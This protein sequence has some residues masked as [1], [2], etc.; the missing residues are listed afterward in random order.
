MARCKTCEK[1]RPKYTARTRQLTRF[2]ITPDDF[3][4]LFEQQGGV[5]ALCCRAESRSD[6]RWSETIWTLAVDHDHGHC[7]N[8]RACKECIRGLL[9]ASC[10]T[11]LGRVEEAG[12]PLV[13]RFSDYLE[14]RPFIRGEGVRPVYQMDGHQI[15]SR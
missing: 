12:E 7:G 5:C 11:M 3:M 1:S 9:C 2:G 14:R 15:G 10:N 8:D 6:P 4:W 13:L